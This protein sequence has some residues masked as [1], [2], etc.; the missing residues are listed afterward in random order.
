MCKHYCVRTKSVTVATSF[1]KALEDAKEQLRHL[2][3][4]RDEI[5]LRLEHAQ[6]A[7]IALAKMLDDAQEASKQLAEMN[8]IVGP[9]GLTDAV[10]RVVQ[11]SMDGFT[12]VEVR[13]M[14]EAMKFDLSKYSNA[15]ATIHTTLKRLEA[16][17]RVRSYSTPTGETV[18]QWEWKQPFVFR[19]A[20]IGKPRKSPARKKTGQSKRPS[21]D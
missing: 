5:N 14:L 19:G 1:Q 11:A 7:I 12:A 16:S 10:S 3:V 21:L 17:K 2:V 18:Y 20:R 4:Q 6:G 13:G 9:S 8:E 15:L